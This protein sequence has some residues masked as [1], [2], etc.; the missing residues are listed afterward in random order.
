[1]W[2]TLEQIIE[3]HFEGTLFDIQVDSDGLLSHGPQLT[4][5]DSS[6]GGKPTAPRVGRAVEIQA[7]WYNAL[8]TMELLAVRYHDSDDAEKYGDAAEKARKSFEKFWNPRKS[9][10][11]DVVAENSPDDSLRPNQI[12]AVSLD[13]VMLNGEKSKSVVEV[14]RDELLT[15]CGLRTLSRGDSRYVGVYAG[16]RSNRDRAYHSGTV[17]PWLLGPFITA[18]LKVNGRSDIQRKYAVDKFL[19]PLLTGR[20]CETGCGTISEIFDGDPPH[21]ARGC[22]SQA[23]S[24]AEPL[25]AYF[26]DVLDIRPKYESKV[27]KSLG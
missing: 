12:L 11:Y 14:V 3:K 15:P 19:K 20:I 6:V 25:R 1:L 5:M 16:D 13:F 2:N 17:W 10:L 21:I 9:C 26:E 4:W 18:F 24:V 7:L 22:I 27:L 23:W 8:K